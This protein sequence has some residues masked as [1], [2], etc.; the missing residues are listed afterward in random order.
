M[1]SLGDF[2]SSTKRAGSLNINWSVAKVSHQLSES[3]PSQPEFLT[4]RAD[5]YT[6]PTEE[7]AALFTHLILFTLEKV[8]SL[9]LRREEPHH[10]SRDY[11]FSFDDDDHQRL[12]HRDPNSSRLRIS[13]ERAA[14]GRLELTN[15]HKQPYIR[16]LLPLPASPM[17]SSRG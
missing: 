14:S 16:L 5:V 6:G 13:A 17:P 8:W 2:L 3:N 10:A 1:L 7:A 12:F 4:R 9:F 11:S 15:L